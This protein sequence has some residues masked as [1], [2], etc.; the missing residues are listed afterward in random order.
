ML[1]FDPQLLSVD[2]IGGYTWDFMP[3]RENPSAETYLS[4]AEADFAEGE[5]PRHLVNSISNA[6]RSLH[7]RLEDL[8]L[9]FG[10][11]NLSKLRKFPPLL[12][13]VRRC[14]IVAPAVLSQLNTLRND[15]EHDFNIPVA[16]EV[17]TFLGVAALFLSSTDRWLNRRP[18]E[19]GYFKQVRSGV[20]IFELVN[21]TFDWKLG[22][23]KLHFRKPGDG[24]SVARTII[25][26][27][28]PSAEFFQCVNFALA[29]SY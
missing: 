13:Y 21:V 14:G 9:G 23:V 5:S 1:T 24:W 8:C 25:E 15:V 3:S 7:L 10:S 28:S 18:L 11:K 27:A 19:I 20:D 2:D 16:R 22:L 12:E 29:N 26:F 4:F 17:T 6:K